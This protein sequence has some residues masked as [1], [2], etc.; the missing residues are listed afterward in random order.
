M[1]SAGLAP[2]SCPPRFKINVILVRYSTIRVVGWGLLQVTAGLHLDYKSTPS[3]S[4]SLFNNER[5]VAHAS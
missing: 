1:C 4:N 3:V 5:S 2:E